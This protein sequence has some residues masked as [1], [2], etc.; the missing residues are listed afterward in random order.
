VRLWKH[1]KIAGEFEM[2]EGEIAERFLASDYAA[3]PWRTDRALAA[4][5]TDHE[6]HGLS[7]VWEDSDPAF[8]AVID[9]IL[10]TP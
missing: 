1:N 6:P 10:A 9:L 5:I 2:P 4:F 7:S 3:Y 8:Y